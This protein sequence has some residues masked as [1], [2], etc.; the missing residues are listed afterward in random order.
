MKVTLNGSPREVPEGSSIADLIQDL[1]MPAQQVAVERNRD[2]VKRSEHAGTR[3][4][5][6]DTLE[7]VSLV[8][9]G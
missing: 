7:I 8:G 1:G 3:L 9:G 4:E 2:L 5:D 6:G